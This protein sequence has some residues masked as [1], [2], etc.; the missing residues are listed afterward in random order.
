MTWQVI[1]VI[2]CELYFIGMTF[3][4]DLRRWRDARNLS[5]HDLASLSGVSQRHLSYLESGKSQPSRGMVVHLGRMLS[6]PLKVQNEL[7]LS[8]G[9]APA[10]TEHKIDDP[11]L[12]SA[13]SA[14]DFILDRHDPHPAVALGRDWTIVGANPA[15]RSLAG[16]LA[17]GDPAV[18]PRMEGVDFLGALARDGELR[19]HMVD[20]DRIVA[21][22]L[23]R[24]LRDALASGDE[25]MKERVTELLASFDRVRLHDGDPGMPALPSIEFRRDGRSLKLLSIMVSFATPCDVTLESVRLELFYPADEASGQLLTEWQ[26]RRQSAGVH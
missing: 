5:Q 15:M 13:R 18:S 14:I 20:G 9:F 4:R 23:E 8:A 10:F 21:N 24:V 2:T 12:A 3:G 1:A 19:R 26:E 17:T 7:L 6:L 11:A 16:F 22:I 25:P